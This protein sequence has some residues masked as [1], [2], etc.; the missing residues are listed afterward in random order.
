MCGY[1]GNLTDSPLTR[2]LMHYLGLEGSLGELRN[3]PGTGPAASVDIILEDGRGRRI[4]PAIWWL[5]LQKDGRGGLRPSRY[6]SFNSRSDKLHQRHSAGYLP[7]RNGRC[8]VPATYLIEGEGPRG[9]RQYHR[10]EPIESAFALGG[11]YR[12]WLDEQTGELTYSC[13]VI[14]LPPHPDQG[15]QRIHSKSTPLMLPAGDTGLLAKWLDPDSDRV[16]D[17]EALLAPCIPQPL[18]CV[19]VLRPGD[20]R[21]VGPAF[22]IEPGRESLENASHPS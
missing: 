9:A 10:V 12:T 19:P 8:I 14:T 6:T 20:Q 4:Q 16:G 13:S 2:V 17:F 21:P 1:I 11:L 5:L 3:N 18:S 7:Y 22:E 15:W